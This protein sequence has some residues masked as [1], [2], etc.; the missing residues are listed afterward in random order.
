MLCVL[1][2]QF[3]FAYEIFI[4]G[5]VSPCSGTQSVWISVFLQ[6]LVFLEF[7]FGLFRFF[8]FVSNV[9]FCRLFCVLAHLL[10]WY[11]LVCFTWLVEMTFYLWFAGIVVLVPSNVNGSLSFWSL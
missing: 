4:C 6:D 11:L 1:S 7:G 9:L 2:N 10:P 5:N 3:E 8:D